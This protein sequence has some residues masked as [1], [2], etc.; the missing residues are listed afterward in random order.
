MNIASI[1]IPILFCAF[2]GWLVVLVGFKSLSRE[3]SLKSF[4]QQLSPQMFEKLSPYIFE[5]LTSR[6]R[7]VEFNDG[8]SILD[9]VKPDI[10]A[11]ADHFLKEKLAEVFP[12]IAKYIGDKTRTQFR[13][14]LMAEIESLFPVILNKYFNILQ[15]DLNLSVIVTEKLLQH[16]STINEQF[17]KPLIRKQFLKFQV[18]ATMIG[19]CVGLLQILAAYIIN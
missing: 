8:S 16:H 3:L 15:Q 6:L 19:A 12:L 17:L 7:G 11:H 13:V 2:A 1:L 18:T 9:K 5:K 14:A 4:W 10:E